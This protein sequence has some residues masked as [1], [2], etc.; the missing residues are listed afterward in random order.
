M[1]TDGG[2]CGDT[3]RRRHLSVQERGPRRHQTSVSDDSSLQDW[4]GMSSC[5]LRC[6]ERFCSI[7][8]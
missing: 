3:G 6:P 8:S 7:P 5:D 4:E 1:H 2:P